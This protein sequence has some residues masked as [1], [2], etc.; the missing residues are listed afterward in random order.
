MEGDLSVKGGF[1][2]YGVVLVTGSITFTGGGAK[3]V[4]EAMLAGGK[5]SAGLI[6]GD[7]TIVYCTQPVSNQI[8]SFPLITLRWKELFS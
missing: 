3:N 6:R 5:A 7:A 2:W 4:T 8:D 1:H